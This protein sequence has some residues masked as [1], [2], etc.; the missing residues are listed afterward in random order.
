[1]DD[2]DLLFPSVLDMAEIDMVGSTLFGKPASNATEAI[3]SVVPWNSRS[4]ANLRKVFCI[5]ALGLIE[6]AAGIPDQDAARVS[7]LSK[8]IRATDVPSSAGAL[9]ID[10]RMVTDDNLATAIGLASIPA[11]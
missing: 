5:K 1:M 9:C 4:P 6:P 8:A 2:G 7:H 11:F 10:A 3:D